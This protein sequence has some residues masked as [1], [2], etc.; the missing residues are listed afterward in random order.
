MQTILLLISAFITALIMFLQ[1][2]PPLWPSADNPGVT[3]RAD[4][5]FYYIFY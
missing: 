3:Q 5:G 1:P 2:L 4:D